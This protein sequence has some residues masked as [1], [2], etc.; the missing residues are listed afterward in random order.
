MRFRNPMEPGSSNFAVF[1]GAYVLL[2]AA[3]AIIGLVVG[4]YGLAAA[5]A[6]AVVLLG[7]WMRR[8]LR[9]ANRRLFDWWRHGDP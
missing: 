5:C 7:L 6:A 3:M 4:L 2:F 8:R 9:R 1:Y